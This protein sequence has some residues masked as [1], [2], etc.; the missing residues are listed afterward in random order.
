[1]PARTIET[2]GDRLTKVGRDN[3]FTTIR[4]FATTAVVFSHA[5]IVVIAGWETADYVHLFG[6]PGKSRGSRLLLPQW[7]SAHHEPGEKTRHPAI[8]D[9]TSV[10]PDACNCGVSSGIGAD[11]QPAG[12]RSAAGGLFQC[13]G[14][15]QFHGLDCPVDSNVCLNTSVFDGK[16]ECSRWAAVDGSILPIGRDLGSPAAWGVDAFDWPQV[17]SQLIV[18]LSLAVPDGWYPAAG[19]HKVASS[20]DAL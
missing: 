8:H 20:I 11:C 3:H 6:S 5:Y 18:D 12:N 9:C 19:A 10:A 13:L 4:A 14:T 17:R 16:M 1:M 7:L 15:D 2:I